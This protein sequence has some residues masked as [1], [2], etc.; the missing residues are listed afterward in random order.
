MRWTSTCRRCSSAAAADDLA[1]GG[2]GA[3]MAAR[4]ESLGVDRRSRCLPGHPARRSPPPGRGSWWS[5]TSANGLPDER[6]ASGVLHKESPCRRRSA[7]SRTGRRSLSSASPNAVRCPRPAGDRGFE[8]WGRPG[9]PRSSFSSK[10]LL[11]EVVVNPGAGLDTHP[12]R[13]VEAQA[14]WSPGFCG[15]R[16]GDGRCGRRIGRWRRPVE[17]PS[18]DCLD[19]VVVGLV[20]VDLHPD[21]VVVGAHDEPLPQ[22]QVGE[23]ATIGDRDEEEV[24]VGDEQRQ[25][26]RAERRGQAL[27]APRSPGGRRAVRRAP[28]QQRVAES[29]VTGAG[30]WRAFSSAAGLQRGERVTDQVSA[31]PKALEN[32]RS[33][34][35][36]SSSSGTAVSP[37]YSKLRASRTGGLAQ[38]GS[39][40]TAAWGLFQAAGGGVSSG[41]PRRSC[42]TAS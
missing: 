12:A 18:R 32:V 17:Q 14:H 27:V 8:V 20:A 25:L 2:V 22:Q 11:E 6:G 28:R 10:A 41:S 5:A 30:T 34:I 16:A 31:R 26:D 36:P 38:S 19:E 3:V 29:V 24:G 4:R 39:G 37:Q 21:P 7:R 23:C 40:R 13:A 1:V 33:T 35:T 9:A 15:S 42:G